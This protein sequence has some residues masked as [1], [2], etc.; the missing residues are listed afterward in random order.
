MTT[1]RQRRRGRE[2]R[3]TADRPGE[4]S[5]RGFDC[6]GDRA[7][8]CFDVNEICRGRSPNR[9]CRENGHTIARRLR[10]D[11]I[12]PLRLRCVSVCPKRCFRR[13]R[14]FLDRDDANG[15]RT[16]PPTR[17]PHCVRKGRRDACPK[18]RH[19]YFPHNS[20]ESPLVSKGRRGADTFSRTSSVR[21][22]IV[23]D[24]GKINKYTHRDAS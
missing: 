22:R 23:S 1:V 10:H 21:T 12:R 6:S 24:D 7:P 8:S 20:R 17:T 2:R 14:T 13:F 18:R 4:I 19:S 9:V 3:A 11:N 16:K 15:R 5:F